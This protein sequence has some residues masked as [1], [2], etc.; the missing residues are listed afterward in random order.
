MR[1]SLRSL[2]LGP[3]ASRTPHP[4]P[5][6]PGLLAGKHIA[7]KENISYSQ[8]PTSCSSQLLQGYIPPYNA[9][10]VDHLINA[11]AHIVG[12]TK[13]DEFGMGQVLTNYKHTT[14]VLTTGGSS[15]GSAAAVAEGSCWAALGTD[16]GGSVR[17]PASYCGV[18]GLKPSY[19]LVSRRGVVA[20]GDSLDCVG[21]LAKDI[22]IVEKVFN[23]ISHPDDRDM[24]CAPS[25]VR[26][27]S[28]PLDLSSTS[29]KNLRIGIPAQ[30]LLPHPY[31]SIPPSLLTH[32]Q[33]LGASLRPV[34]L[35]SVRKALPA[36]YVLASAE[37]SSNLGRYGGGWYGSEAE[38]EAGRIEGES[39]QERRVRVRSD[40]FG[41]E[42]KKRILAGTHALS[43]DEFNNTYL[44]A[45]YLRR[46]LRQEYQRTFRIAHPLAAPYTPNSDGV[47]LILHP[48]AIRT[49]PLLNQD[50]KT[51]E[52]VYLQDLITVPPSLAG[53]PAMSVP[54]GKAEDGWPVGMSVTGQWGM[55]GL[56]FG[57]GR[58]I[59]GWA[60]NL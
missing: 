23:I 36:Y 59:E 54:A 52:S 57:L 18:V 40:G 16:T 8:A 21:V 32:L 7:I 6:P 35:P 11:G 10:C 28:L 17:L 29:L 14:I 19:G 12:T 43:A 9:A 39:G 48:T 51:G 55:E 38:K 47:D 13:M 22:D 2:A 34:S 44:K 26:S 42:V 37:A 1:A 4:A 33:S 50:A 56:V 15:G 49:A 46:L 24:T 5:A 25:S 20:Y 27:T 58:A 45:L 3:Y 53:L 31:T 41:K 60:R 30:T